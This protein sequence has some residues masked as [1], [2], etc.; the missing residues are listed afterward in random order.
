M[1]GDF[2]HAETSAAGAKRHRH[3]LTLEARKLLKDF[4]EHVSM[5]PDSHQRQHLLDRVRRLHGCGHADTKHITVWFARYRNIAKKKSIQDDDSILFTNFTSEQLDILRPLLRNNPFPKKK[6]IDVWSVCI[7]A[8]P[9]Q[10]SKW[11]SYHQA[12][13][14]PLRGTPEQSISVSP[15]APLPHLPTPA[16]SLSPAHARDMSLPLIAAKEEASPTSPLLGKQWLTQ[17]VPVSHTSFPQQTKVGADVL[18]ERNPPFMR[19]PSLDGA[20]PL[21]D[22]PTTTP[23]PVKQLVKDIQN[24]ITS[25]RPGSSRKPST[26]EE[27]NAMF[28][29]YEKMMTQF[30]NNVENGKLRHLGWEPSLHEAT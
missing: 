12:K 5:Y 15:T 17:T 2:Q 14:A 23:S 29:P 25:H 26:H 3:R 1:E 4:A 18:D 28:K 20:R 9:E 6:M 10:V 13:A 22:V 19:K 21:R 8:E 11:V 16:R 27:F 7:K 30:I 24:S